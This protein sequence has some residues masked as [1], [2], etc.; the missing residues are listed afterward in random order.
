[1]RRKIFISCA[2]FFCAI[3]AV[4]GFWFG[5]FISF[6]KQWP[7]FEALR[8]TASIIFAVVGA[9]MAIIYP[10]RL[11]ISFGK[12]LDGVDK[13]TSESMKLLMTPAIH[14]TFILAIL[15]LIGVV[16]PIL[17][18]ISYIYKYYELFRGI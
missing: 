3:I 9:W 7:L 8:N 6:E 12:K 16:A 2:V 18:Q 1:M 13:T 11:K 17:K 5:R 15:L 10:E 4:A 14:S